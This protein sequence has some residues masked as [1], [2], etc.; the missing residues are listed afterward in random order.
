METCHTGERFDATHQR[1][2]RRQPSAAR[3]KLTAQEALAALEPGQLS[4]ARQTARYGRRVL[5]RGALTVFWLLRVYVIV[6]FAIVV[7]QVWG[8]LH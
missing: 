3:A 2:S 1:A 7:Y 8:A 6:M 5:S 4:R